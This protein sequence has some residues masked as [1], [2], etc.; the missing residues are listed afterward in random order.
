M[1]MD[2]GKKHIMSLDKSEADTGTKEEEAQQE[3]VYSVYDEEGGFVCCIGKG[4]GW[5]TKGKGKGKGKF[6]GVCY[7]C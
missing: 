1:P 4:C 5:Q 7:N 3:E 6:D 2:V